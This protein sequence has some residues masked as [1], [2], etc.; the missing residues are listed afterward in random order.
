MSAAK[1]KIA[2]AAIF[3]II[4]GSLAAYMYNKYIHNQP[5]RE[6]IKEHRTEIDPRKAD[7]AFQAEGERWKK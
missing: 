5:K 4:L 2:T 7:S 3:F 1:K 6:W